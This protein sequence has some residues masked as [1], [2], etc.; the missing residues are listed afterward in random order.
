MHQE[1]HPCRRTGVVIALLFLLWSTEAPAHEPLRVEFDVAPVVA[2][3]DVTTPEFAAANPG[4]KLVEGAINIS[5]LL[6]EGS[7]D[8]LVQFLYRIEALQD[9][10]DGRE[11]ALRI[12]DHLPR[13]ELATPLAGPISVD[14]RD[15]S[16]RSAGAGIGLAVPSETILKTDAS[17]HASRKTDVTVRY[18]L[19]PPKELLAASGTLRRERG[20]YFKLRPSRQT[21]LEGARQ[22]V[23]VLRV[24]AGWR[25][26]CVR[27]HCEAAG[28]KRGVVRWAD[29]QAVCGSADFTVGLHA[30]SDPQARDAVARA[31]RAD[32]TLRESVAR[33]RDCLRTR[34]DRPSIP[35]YGYVLGWLSPLTD[36]ALVRGV[37]QRSAAGQGDEKWPADVRAAEEEWAASR[38]AM[39]AL[40]DL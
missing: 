26:D 8:D 6:H 34:L 33:H 18:E 16:T 17:V 24:P 39:E 36:E 1:R 31:A 32:E 12:V 10:A 5:S 38:A 14:R 40:G 35:V 29:R 4:E 15:E 28:V 7:E 2:C 30:E 11:P 21:S 13:T 9:P 37:I 20:V 27:V 3:R 23:V 19:L 25:G 22:F